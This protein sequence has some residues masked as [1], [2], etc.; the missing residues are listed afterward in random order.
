M[1]CF[2]S[3]LLTSRVEINLNLLARH[4][5]VSTITPHWKSTVVVQSIA[6]LVS[7]SPQSIYRLYAL[8]I[9][10]LHSPKHFKLVLDTSTLG[11]NNIWIQFGIYATLMLVLPP[12]CTTPLRLCLSSVASLTSQQRGH[13]V[14]VAVWRTREF[15]YHYGNCGRCDTPQ[16]LSSIASYCH[17]LNFSLHCK[18]PMPSHQIFFNIKYD[19]TRRARRF[20]NPHVI[21]PTWFQHV[22]SW[23]NAPVFLDRPFLFCFL[24]HGAVL[25]V[26]HFCFFIELTEIGRSHNGGLSWV[27]GLMGCL[28]G[29]FAFCSKPATI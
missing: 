10:K 9:H 21:F 13:E 6:W 2:V 29:I 5:N 25:H 17:D 12:S 7:I 1:C 19:P 24:P 23:E 14:S 4:Y 28:C 15:P 18:K 26:I 27:R 3:Y 16:S 8:I 11:F 22:R 20:I